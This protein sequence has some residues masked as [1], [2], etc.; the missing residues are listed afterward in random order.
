M[1][2][3]TDRKS[4]ILA[5]ATR[6]FAASGFHGVS[7]DDLG[8][9]LGIS[10]PAI[11]RYFPGKEAILADMLVGISQR[12]LDGANER[13]A[14]NDTAADRLTALIDFH[15]D[16]ALTEPDLIA[17]QFRDLGSAPLRERQQVRKLQRLYVNLWADVLVQAYPE[18]S[19][20][21]ALSGVQAVFGLLNSTPHSGRSGDPELA[22]VLRSMAAAAL[23]AVGDSATINDR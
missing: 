16:F 17:V 9:E 23:A 19:R 6:L 14:A 21:R 8:A 7:I 10:G 13:I 2:P 15:V 4:E 12:L 20:E 3:R 11:Y 22:S 18:L 1:P 5:A